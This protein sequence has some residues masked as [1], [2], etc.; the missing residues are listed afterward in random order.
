MENI[1]FWVINPVI[2]APFAEVTSSYGSRAWTTYSWCTASSRM[3][4]VPKAW[5]SSPSNLETKEMSEVTYCRYAWA[6]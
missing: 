4:L 3:A 6:L 2:V 5:F 1:I